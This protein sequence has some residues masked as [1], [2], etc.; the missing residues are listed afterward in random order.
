MT[1]ATTDPGPPRQATHLEAAV[2]FGAGVV[3]AWAV[4]LVGSA[5]GYGLTAVVTGRF[6]WPP[7]RPA[8]IS[9]FGPLGVVVPFG[10][11]GFLIEA[12]RFQ[13]RP[14]PGRYFR[15]WAGAGRLRQRLFVVL[16]V[17]AV[18]IGVFAGLG[19]TDG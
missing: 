1:T 10:M 11:A 14:R 16:G 8:G 19:W 13:G 4:L 3:K 12:L 7:V 15:A 2:L 18:G 17:A 5:V 6:E 9:S